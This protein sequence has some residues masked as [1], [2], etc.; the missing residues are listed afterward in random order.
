MRSAA[1]LVMA[2]ILG[3]TASAQTPVILS[4]P[5]QTIRILPD[6]TLTQAMETVRCDPGWL[7]AIARAN[8]LTAADLAKIRYGTVLAVPAGLD[9]RTP[10]PAQ[11][12]AMSRTLVNARVAVARATVLT[13]T[14]G[15]LKGQLESLRT[16][17][18]S[19][20]EAGTVAAADRES[21][22]NA[23]ALAQQ[24]LTD[25]TRERDILIYQLA[26]RWPAW[27]TFLL[28]FGLA[29]I[30]LVGAEVWRRRVHAPRA[31]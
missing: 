31:A 23:A 25:V 8:T 24:R 6:Q 7:A 21:A 18:A 14:V 28:G 10:A 13:S 2:L 29:L 16:D 22:D 3:A 9:C 19:A 12:A 4:G 11:E 20:R 30:L 27:T 1:I 26:R 15:E 17:L 5:P